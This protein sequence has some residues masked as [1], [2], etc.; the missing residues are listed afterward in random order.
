MN[1]INAN[2]INANEINSIIKSVKETGL[3]KSASSDSKALQID[4]SVGQQLHAALILIQL[5]KGH[6]DSKTMCDR[7]VELMGK[8]SIS[9]D[10]LKKL[11][12]SDNPDYIK[13]IQIFHK[14]LNKLMQIGDGLKVE[15]ANLDDKYKKIVA[16]INKNLGSEAIKA[17]A[18][19]NATEGI[20]FTNT[21]K[22]TY[23]K[24]LS[25]RNNR[26][27]IVS[28]ENVDPGTL[29]CEKNGNDEFAYYETTTK[30]RKTVSTII[31]NKP[32]TTKE[33]QALTDKAKK[34]QNKTKFAG[35]IIPL[36]KAEISSEQ[37]IGKKLEENIAGSKF[38]E[39][40]TS[41]IKTSLFGGACSSLKIDNSMNSN[42]LYSDVETQ[43]ASLEHDGPMAQPEYIKCSKWKK[44]YLTQFDIKDRNIIGGQ[45]VSIPNM[46][47][48][49]TNSSQIAYILKLKEP[50][51]ITEKA[52]KD[53]S[54]LSSKYNTQGATKADK[55]KLLSDFEAYIMKLPDYKKDDNFIH[56]SIIGD[57][58]NNVEKFEQTKYEGPYHSTLTCKLIPEI[59]T[60]NTSNQI[61]NLVKN[62]NEEINYEEL[63]QKLK[64]LADEVNKLNK[65][66]SDE[67]SKQDNDNVEKYKKI[68][69]KIKELNNK[70]L[71]IIIKLLDINKNGKV[72]LSNMDKKLVMN[73]LLD[74]FALNRITSGESLKSN[75]ED[76]QR[77]VTAVSELV[78]TQAELKETKD[79][80]KET[81]SELARTKD[82]LANLKTKDKR[83][84]SRPKM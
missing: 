62:N 24:Q 56:S 35:I 64:P 11:R 39:Y 16:E 13:N 51:V 19:E 45:E 33:K 1:K 74:K 72:D 66:Y 63:Y 34:Q 55:D 4:I 67:L 26:F 17:N 25:I 29:Y 59:R 15:Y 14:E 79:Q 77:E 50:I 37:I 47:D 57:F 60:P 22:A 20:T 23:H 48:F 70:F 18:N 7:L 2:E 54:D 73:K 42:P 12:P 61:E 32:L 3:E 46:Q 28:A 71:D 58:S 78:K 27:G 30:D 76:I 69:S 9:E 36:I 68:D 10:I 53:L 84:Q 41:D 21:S 38:L 6:E 40:I 75:I 43:Q 31:S 52:H 80:L 81:Q 82:E 83:Y 5:K 8:S 65:K 49:L 44:Y